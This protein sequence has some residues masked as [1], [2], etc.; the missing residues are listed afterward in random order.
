MPDSNDEPSGSQRSAPPHTPPFRG[1]VGPAVARPALRPVLAMH[2]RMTVPPFLPPIERGGPRPGTPAQPGML[3]PPY[4]APARVPAYTPGTQAALDDAALAATVTAE[5]TTG[6]VPYQG[7]PH[8]GHWSAELR[9][10][11]GTVDAGDDLAA[12]TVEL[13]R[14]VDASDTPDRVAE[15]SADAGMQS[16]DAYVERPVLAQQDADADIR[17]D[18]S[19]ML[20][21]RAAPPPPTLFTED[22]YPPHASMASREIAAAATSTGGVAHP[23]NQVE[24][25]RQALVDAIVGAVEH[26]AIDQDA[27]RDREI[28]HDAMRLFAAGAFEEPLIQHA[29]DV[30]HESAEA[31]PPPMFEDD[32]E[33]MHDVRPDG[34]NDFVDASYLAQLPIPAEP[35]SPPGAVCPSPGT[36][37]SVPTTT[38]AMG[39][40]A[41]RPPASAYPP[42]EPMGRP[43]RP[44]PR[45]VT[46]VMPHRVITPYSTPAIATRPVRATPVRS[47]TPIYVSIPTPRSVPA[48]PDPAAARAV[49]GALETVAAQIRAGHLVVTGDVP[50]GTDEAT[51]AAYLA[52]ALAALLG[53][54][55]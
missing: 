6:G 14:V 45:R 25:E 50:Q 27:E 26:A 16:I 18:A 2:G 28:D 24:R 54:R 10:S 12:K 1:P 37:R 38:P 20:R 29:H 40:P 17:T 4:I 33:V 8:T 47:P 35:W 19:V 44:T 43:R 7:T 11:P 21:G 31:P 49:A 9:G 13:V 46:P 15:S 52:A 55:H 41:T 3:V 39:N 51:Q 23:A 53:V 34:V 48:V 5:H 36:P 30:G 32:S 22:P 42:L